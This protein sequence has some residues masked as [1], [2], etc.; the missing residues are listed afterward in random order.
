MCRHTGATA[1]PS[2]PQRRASPARSC[3]LCH[4][5]CR[6][7]PP[8]KLRRKADALR[9]PPLEIQMRAGGGQG[10]LPLGGKPER[11][12]MTTIQENDTS[13]CPGCGEF[14]EGPSCLG[15]F[16]VES[17]DFCGLDAWVELF[18]CRV[19]STGLGA[20]SACRRLQQGPVLCSTC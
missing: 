20:C 16:E 7:T 19:C 4:A 5:A 1:P 10:G 18:E 2:P 9:L 14:P 17:C 8:R 12:A 6:L 15:C 3:G 13:M 11:T